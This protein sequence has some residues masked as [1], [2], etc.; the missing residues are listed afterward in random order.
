MKDKKIIALVVVIVL[1]LFGLSFAKTKEPKPVD[2]SATFINS[3][4]DPYGTYITYELLSDI[5]EKKKIRTTRV[6]VYNN[7]SKRLDEYYSYDDVSYDTNTIETYQNTDEYQDESDYLIEDSIVSNEYLNDTTDMLLHEEYDPTAWFHEMDNMSDTTSYVFINSRFKVDKLDL[8]YLLEFVGLG[9]NVFIS[10]ETI[11]Q[12]LLDTLKIKAETQYFQTD[13]IYNMTDYP[14]R[15]YRFGNVLGQMKFNTDSCKLPLR[16]LAFNNKKDTVFIDI[17]YGK[18]HFYLH[19]VP[20]AFANVNMLQTEKYDF[21]FRCLS[22]L[23]QNSKIIWD[24]YLKQGAVNEGSQFRAMLNN[25]PLRIALYI[26]LGGL[27]LFMIFRAKRTQRVIPVINPPVN[28][29]L[30][31]L[32]TISNLYYRKSDFNTIVEK[33][34]AYFL[35]FIRKNYYMSTESTNSDFINLLSAKSMMD[36]DKLT[37]LFS[38]YQNISTLAF[39]SNDMFLKYNSLLEEFYKNVKNK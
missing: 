37:E 39:I 2:W 24:E 21:G 5:F 33:R 17:S 13:T 3:K 18:G 30:E 32:G 20:T 34:H 36:R 25:P 15:K 4:T 27:L 31:F 9:N 19:A 16:T 28:S 8:E 12:Q 6:P 26:I 29:S 11:D 1:L 23:P 35:D 14:E 7:L 10:A 38:L 22:Y